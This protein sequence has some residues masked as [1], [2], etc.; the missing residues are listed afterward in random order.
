M[1]KFQYLLESAYYQQHRLMEQEDE[2]LLL[3]LDP[4]CQTIRDLQ[5]FMLQQI[6]D[7]YTVN[8]AIEGN[9]SVTHLYRPPTYNSRLTTPRGFN[10][11]ARIIKIAHR[12]ACALGRAWRCF[13]YKDIDHILNSEHECTPLRLPRKMVSMV[14]FA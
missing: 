3:P 9:E 1:M 2:A 4:H 12:R 8:L 11:D 13:R 5:I 7:G 14:I 10:Y 6:N